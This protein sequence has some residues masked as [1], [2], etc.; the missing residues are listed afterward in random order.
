MAEIENSENLNK[1]FHFRNTECQAKN[2]INRNIM[3]LNDEPIIYWSLSVHISFCLVFSASCLYRFLLYNSQKSS[4]IFF[5]VFVLIHH[6]HTFIVEIRFTSRIFLWLLYPSDKLFWHCLLAQVTSFDT[7]SW[8]NIK[9]F[10][11]VFKVWFDIRNKLFFNSIVPLVHY[12]SIR[13]KQQEK[14][15]NG[16]FL[17]FLFLN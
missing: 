6:I 10:W 14:L 2:H 5:Y 13:S 16:N 11:E 15:R 1:Y 17:S 4:S 12:V 9:I 8:T 7:I 3:N